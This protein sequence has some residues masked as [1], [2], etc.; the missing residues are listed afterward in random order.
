VV[1]SGAGKG[2]VRAVV[3]HSFGDAPYRA[4][5]YWKML[6]R[7]EMSLLRKEKRNNE[8]FVTT[9]QYLDFEVDED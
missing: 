4:Q 3:W 8:F 7:R 5:E 2:E 1:Y 6:V 9:R